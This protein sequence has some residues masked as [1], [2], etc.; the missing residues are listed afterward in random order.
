MR[1]KILINTILTA[2]VLYCSYA[3]INYLILFF[4]NPVLIGD[5][6]YFFMGNII[7]FLT[8]FIILTASAAVLIIVNRKKQK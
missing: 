1:F 5:K 6:S 3:C 4:E 2:V 8:F 7:L